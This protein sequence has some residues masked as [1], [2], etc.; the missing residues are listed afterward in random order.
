MT[1]SACAADLRLDPPRSRP[2]FSGVLHHDR[3]DHDGVMVVLKKPAIPVAVLVLQDFSDVLAS[4]LCTLA[5]Q[6]A[7]Q[8][9]AGQD[10]F[11]RKK[12]PA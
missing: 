10:P 1:V 6:Q 3:H 2:Q 5:L 4:V 11:G 9:N 12:N 8:P 7:V